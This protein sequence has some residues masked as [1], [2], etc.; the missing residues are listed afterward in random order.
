MSAS[1]KKPW[2]FNTRLTITVVAAVC[3]AGTGQ[4]VA[5]DPNS[6]TL[7]VIGVCLSLAAV[8]CIAALGFFREILDDSP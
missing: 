7:R 6:F 1:P 5:L 4:I 2:K 8:G 3:S